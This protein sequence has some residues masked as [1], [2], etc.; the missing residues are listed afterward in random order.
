MPYLTDRMLH[1]HSNEISVILMSLTGYTNGLVADC[2]RILEKPT[3]EDQGKSL[4]AA[5]ALASYDPKNP[6]WSN[7]RDDVAN[8]LVAE[9]AYGV[10]SWIDALLPVANQ[11]RD[12]LVAIFHDDK[13]G[14]SERTL[15]A[16]A[17]AEYLDDQPRVLTKLLM[18]AIEKQFGTLSG[19]RKAI[20]PD[21]STSR[22]RS[23]PEPPCPD[24]ARTH[25]SRS[26]GMGQVL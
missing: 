23:S 5:C 8:R 22:F 12:P 21:Q 6:R 13:R 18:D 1:A 9:N 16:S 24:R 25:G 19:G 2:W 26:R 20:G 11:L 4:Q 15:A 14:E 17:L 10:A 7:I 3:Q